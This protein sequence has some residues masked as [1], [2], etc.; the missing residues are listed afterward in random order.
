M[1]LLMKTHTHKK[2]CSNIT[3]LKGSHGDL[4]VDSVYIDTIC[5]LH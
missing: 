3:Q 2:S 1:P 4:A 5:S